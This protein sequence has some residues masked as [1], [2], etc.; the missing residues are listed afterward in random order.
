[1]YV[2]YTPDQKQL[3]GR[4]SRYFGE[5]MTPDPGTV[6]SD[7]RYRGAQGLDPKFIQELEQRFGVLTRPGL[8]CA[9]H[10]HRT[11]GPDPD[12][13]A[14]TLLTAVSSVMLGATML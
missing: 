9:P 7:S 5:L 3:A 11:F 8:H 1:M 13:A 4:L 14:I 10:V 6:G 12:A 2:D